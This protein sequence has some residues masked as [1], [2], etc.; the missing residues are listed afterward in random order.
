MAYVS[1]RK[2]IIVPEEL[3]LKVERFGEMYYA[4]VGRGLVCTSGLRSAQRQ[5]EAM[6][7]NYV[8]G[9][10]VIYK[11]QSYENEIKSV[12]TECHNR[13]TTPRERTIAEMTMVIE[14][15]IRRGAYISAHLTGNAAD[16]SK[17]MTDIAVFSSIALVNC[18]LQVESSCLHTTFLT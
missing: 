10:N 7:E 16:W 11:N 5:A 17:I 9:R 18:Y 6:H 1:Y 14:A 12:W 2:E 8:L 3:K 13:P 15:Q 4:K